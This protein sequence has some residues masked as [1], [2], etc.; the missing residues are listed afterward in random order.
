MPSPAEQP[1]PP[2]A[3]LKAWRQAQAV[4]FDVDSTVSPDEGIDVLAAC[5]GVQEQVVALTRR[6]MGGAVPFHEALRA[7]LD[8]I[9]PDRV[10]VERCLREH[11][12]R[13]TTGIAALVQAL[14][15]RG[16]VVHLVSGGFEPFVLPLAAQ[17][18]IPAERC[19]ANAFRF[20]ADG[21]YA[22]FDAD[23]PTAR[24]GGKAA[25]LAAL[26]R[27]YGYRP[28]VM[29]GDGATDLQARPPADLMIGFGGIAVREAVRTGADWFVTRFE[30]LTQALE[31]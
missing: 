27:Q 11:P 9:R 12:P 19:A 28:L 17:L 18:G 2:P 10:L 23:R 6:A 7:R 14:R 24:E 13:L 29:V 22:G 21:G 20:T 30:T 15:G 5:A 25:V 8:L 16:V 31:G 1:L 4:C 26:Q 3:V